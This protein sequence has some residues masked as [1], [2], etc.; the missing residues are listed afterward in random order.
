MTDPTTLTIVA[1][2]LGIGGLANAIALILHL[3]RHHR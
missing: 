1:I 3:N 2:L